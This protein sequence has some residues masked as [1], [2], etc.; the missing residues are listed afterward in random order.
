MHN[1]INLFNYFYLNQ[2]K[3]KERS[4][5]DHDQPSK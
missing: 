1:F 4:E 2:I 3:E 5:Q